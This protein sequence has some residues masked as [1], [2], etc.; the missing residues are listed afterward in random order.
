[1]GSG[2]KFS[3]SIVKGFGLSIFVDTFP[4]ALSIRLMVGWFII[5]MGFGKGY[6]E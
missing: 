4:H 1:M 3:I 2:D 6:D 5:Y